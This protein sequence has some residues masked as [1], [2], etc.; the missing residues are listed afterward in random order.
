ML[1]PQDTFVYKVFGVGKI[2]FV[3]ENR[4]DR[5]ALLRD[6][7]V[8]WLLKKRPNKSTTHQNNRGLF[9]LFYFDRVLNTRLLSLLGGCKLSL[10]YFTN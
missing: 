9:Y 3:Q 5:K 1:V 10:V 4:T 2:Y 8:F 7:G 6:W